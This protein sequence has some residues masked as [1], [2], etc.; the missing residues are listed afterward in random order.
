MSGCCVCAA[1]LLNPPA[2]LA[3]LC[4]VRATPSEAWKDRHS[5]VCLMSIVAAPILQNLERYSCLSPVLPLVAGTPSSILTVL[6][7][8]APQTAIFFMTFLLL[9]ASFP[10]VQ[11]LS[12]PSHV[13]WCARYCHPGCEQNSTCVLTE[14]CALHW[15]RGSCPSR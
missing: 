9:Q 1:C 2:H 13:Q 4:V 11:L 10:I 14:S 3:I 12:K 6:G 15:C 5:S 8:A 7:T